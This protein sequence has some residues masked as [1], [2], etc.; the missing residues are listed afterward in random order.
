TVRQPLVHYD[1]K[2]DLYWARVELPPGPDGTRRRPRVTS[3]DK[4]ELGRK[5]RKL[6]DE[7]D[8]GTVRKTKGYTVRSW[9]D[10]YLAHYAPEKSAATYRDVLNN[11][12]L[13]YLPRAGNLRL[14]RLTHEHV[15]AMLAKLKRRGLSNGSRVKAR[16]VLSSVLKAAHLRHEVR[17]NVARLAIAP[18]TEHAT[19]DALTV[20]EV[21]RVLAY[22]DGD[23]GKEPRAGR[24]RLAALAY[25]ALLVGMRQAECLDLRWADVDLKRGIVR[26]F[27][28]REEMAKTRAS[29]RRV[30]LPARA[31]DALRLHHEAQTL[32]RALAPVW[33]DQADLVFATKLGTRIDRR[34]CLRWWHRVT[35]GAGVGRRRFHASRHTAATVMLNNGT[36][37]EVV[38]QILGHSRMSTTADFY[39]EIDPEL[40]RKGSAA[41]DRALAKRR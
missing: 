7:I 12:C 11:W 23:R 41:I 32:E 14:D 2:R 10:Y 38:Q 37:L 15:D 28:G 34:N 19:K 6:L 8:R 16:N 26:V 29:V 24:D 33:H 17:E 18:P 5:L 4:A 27:V 3:R 35:E 31:L 20:P 30:P 39:A 25:L 40:L 1:R 9:S 21:E 13:P 22:V 36:D